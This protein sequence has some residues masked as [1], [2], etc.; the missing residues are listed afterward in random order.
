[1]ENLDLNINH[2]SVIDI[3]NFF[4]LKKKYTM[5][6]IES[7]EY[8][9]R[10]Q[11]LKSGHINKRFKRDLIEFLTTAK[12]I[13]VA[14]IGV[15]TPTTVPKN[16]RLDNLNYPYSTDIPYSKEG[17]VIQRPDKPFQY[18][19]NDEFYSG[20]LNPLSTRVVHKC[21]TI[22]TRFRENYYYTKSTDFILQLPYKINKAVSMQLS[23]IELPI[24]FYGIFS[25]LWK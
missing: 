13:L 17:D 23:A 12:R 22:D 18:V 10:E 24:S 14:K 5:E 21:L 15:V 6:D 25:T 11:L 7:R 1:M 16:A 20:S 2:Y 3:E 4:G 8:T 9:I 19:K